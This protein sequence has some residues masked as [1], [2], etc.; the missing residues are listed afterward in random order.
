MSNEKIVKCPICE[1][2]EHTNHF[3]CVKYLHAD[4]ERIIQK[5]SSCQFELQSALTANALLGKQLAEA[6]KEIARLNKILT[7]WNPLARH[8]E[9]VDKDKRIAEPK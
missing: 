6:K 8:D 3:E 5:L 4:R 1:Y 7:D 2:F 9:M